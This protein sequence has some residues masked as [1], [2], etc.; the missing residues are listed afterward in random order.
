MITI[1]TIDIDITAT[2]LYDANDQSGIIDQDRTVN[3]TTF[4]V[5]TLDISALTDSAADI[6]TL[7]D[8]ITGVDEAMTDLTDA[9]T[10]ARRRQVAHRACSRT[11]SR[12]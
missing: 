12:A 6:Q 7:E 4:K 1:G 2:E 11:S 3:A 5:S 10:D 8:Y 9:A